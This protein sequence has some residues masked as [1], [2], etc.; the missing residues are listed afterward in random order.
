L[1]HSAAKVSNVMAMACPP[2]GT[3]RAFR[4]KVEAL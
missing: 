4:L 2:V 3:A 1:R